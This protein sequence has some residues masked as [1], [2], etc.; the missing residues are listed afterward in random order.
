MKKNQEVVDSS[1]SFD[2]LARGGFFW[3]G[4]G[5]LQIIFMLAGIS[6]SKFFVYWINIILLLVAVLH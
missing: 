1:S 4:G 2:Y 5:G 6:G 3:G